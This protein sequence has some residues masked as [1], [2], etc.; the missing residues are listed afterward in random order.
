MTSEISSLL[1]TLTLA[2]AAALLSGAT[3]WDSRALPAKGVLSFVMSDGPH[4]IR[5][6]LGD[7]D[8][9]GIAASEPSTCFP[10]A[11]TLANSWDPELAEEMGRALGQEALALGVDVVLGPGLNIKRSPLCGRNFEYYSEDPLLS[12]RMAA[13]MVRGI[14]EQGVAATPKHFAVNSQELRRMASDSVLDERTMREIYLTAFEI[15]VREA[16]PQVLMSSYN[17]VNGV[18]AHENPLLLTGILRGEWGFDGMVVSDWGGSNSAV[19]A[20]AAGGSLEM[21]APGLSSVREI[22]TAV[23]EGRL[24]EADVRAR[25]AEV[26]RLAADPPSTRPDHPRL[27]ADAHHALARRISTRSSVLLKNRDGLLPLA[28]GTR[29]ALVGDMART[30]RYQ[31]SGSSQVNPTRLENLLD[32]VASTDLHLVGHA[33]GYDRQGAP[34]PVLVDEAVALARRSD[35]VI[36]AIGLDELSESEG[37]DRRHMR[38]PAVQ[39]ELL[40]RIA[41]VNAKVVVVLSSGS[42]VECDWEKDAAAVLHTCLSGQAGAS[43]TWDLLTGRA[44]PSGRLAETWPLHLE[45]HPSADLVPA[46]GPV[47]QYREALYVGYRYFAHT[48]TPVAHPFG[49]GLSYASFERRILAVDGHGVDVEV[50]NTSERDGCDVIQVYVE[51]PGRVWGPSRTLAAFR[52]VEVPAGAVQKVRID[53]DEYGLRHWD[54]QTSSWQREA[55]EWSVC[56]GTDAMHIVDRAALTLEGT[57]VVAPAPPAPYV[58]GQVRSVAR[59]DF[60]ALLGHPLPPTEDPHDLAEDSPLS[61]MA[62]ARSALAR[63]AARLLERKRRQ[64]D[65]KGHPDLNI[66]F[67]QNMPFRALGKM[68][69]GAVTPEAVDGIVD[70]ANGRTWRGLR[71]T[72]SALVRAKRD[73]ARTRAELGVPR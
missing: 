46:A 2:E 67:V 42:A 44:E 11:A 15:V 18:H 37:L 55:G 58:D 25:A 49:F 57:D 9:L 22:V 69:K 28:P 41:Q 40:A 3:E 31:G 32:E 30:P 16:H 48:N 19:A 1:D 60:E 7:G 64:A 62:G 20:V 51:R 29:I 12:G 39:T 4:G 13:G 52:R 10:T 53:L 73:D 65:A 27:E 47:S 63:M 68:T 45:D 50:R 66:L 54:G 24:A 70:L 56:L 17:K 26:L 23:Q 21:P 34:R 71:R 6:Q 36:L 14:Q 35:V 5:R 38:L 33:Q 8:H 61:A 59:A 43:A 72:A